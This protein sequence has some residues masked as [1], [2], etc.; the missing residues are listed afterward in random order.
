MTLVFTGN[1]SGS[2]KGAAT[3]QK[4][5]PTNGQTVSIN[6]GTGDVN[7]YL[8]PATP[9]AALTLNLPAIPVGNMLYITSTQTI[10]LLTINGATI[11]NGVNTLM[12]NDTLGLL[13]V[14]T[15]TFS[16]AVTS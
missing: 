9:L 3:Q 10:T 11:F 2:G 12:A 16:R 7:L 13:K 4:V 8:T 6:S 1:G 14:D 15:D 5:T